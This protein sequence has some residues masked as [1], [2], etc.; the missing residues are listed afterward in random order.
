MMTIEEITT[1]LKERRTV[2]VAR[3]TGLAYNT[4]KSLKAGHRRAYS[5]TIEKL[6]RYLKPM[7][8]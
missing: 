8:G 7:E 2:D 6:S 1:A 4:I 5:D 3:A